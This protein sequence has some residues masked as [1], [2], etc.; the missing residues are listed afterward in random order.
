MHQKSSHTIGKSIIWI[1]YWTILLLY[2]CS[3]LSLYHLWTIYI[4]QPPSKKNQGCNALVVFIDIL[5]VLQEFVFHLNLLG[6]ICQFGPAGG[7]Y[8]FA[9]HENLLFQMMLFG[10]ILQFIFFVLN[11]FNTEE[12]FS[13]MLLNYLYIYF[14]VQYQPKNPCLLW[15]WLAMSAIDLSFLVIALYTAN[16]QELLWFPLLD[17]RTIFSHHLRS[18]FVV[19]L[20]FGRNMS[21]D[22]YYGVKLLINHYIW[23]L[24][25]TMT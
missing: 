13:R 14:P 3:L 16:F 9:F 23:L 17:H 20:V 1:V 11:A 19:S 12:I 6:F 8:I 10:K 25:A 5:N 22:Y 18:D 21:F 2:I 15:I 24:S 7:G 4:F